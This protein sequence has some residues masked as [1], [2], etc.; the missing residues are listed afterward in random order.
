MEAKVQ[1]KS[2]I[3]MKLIWAILFVLFYSFVVPHL[4]DLLQSLTV[5]LLVFLFYLFWSEDQK[6]IQ[7]MRDSYKED[8]YTE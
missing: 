7:K 2:N 5:I 4:P 8:F 1:K 3:F 6:W